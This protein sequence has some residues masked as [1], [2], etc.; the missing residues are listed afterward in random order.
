M[1]LDMFIQKLISEFKVATR[2]GLR[3]DQLSDRQLAGKFLHEA[4]DVAEAITLSGNYLPD[5]FPTLKG[6]QALL[7]RIRERSTVVA[8]AGQSQLAV[9]S[10]ATVTTGAAGAK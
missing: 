8:P 9:V 2:S 4:F 10:P 5:I 6:A 1:A 7:A 3:P